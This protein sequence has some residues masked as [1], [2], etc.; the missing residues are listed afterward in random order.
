MLDLRA[1]EVLDAIARQGSFAQAAR[2][3]GRV[4]S[5]ITYV[6]QQLEHELGV[7]LFDRSGHRAVLT[8]AGEELVGEGRQLMQHAEALER[9]VQRV[10][11]GWE[12]ELRIAV[13]ALIRMPAVLALAGAFLQQQPSTRLRLS[14]EVLG[15]T[16]DALLSRRCDLALGT[17]SRP[18]AGLETAGLKSR[19]LGPYEMIFAVAPGHPLAAVKEPLS[20]AEVRQHRAIAIADTSRNLPAVTVN[21]LR[22]QDVLTVPSL[23]DKIDAQVAGLGCGYLPQGLISAHLSAGLLVQKR[24][25]DRIE[26]GTLEYSWNS[27]A[28]GHAMHWFL[29]RLEDPQVRAALLPS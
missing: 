19:Q 13:D 14:S 25:A 5:A 4:P 27:D 21:L 7:L 28:H 8:A 29:E 18:A 2:E 1:L 17:V 20:R 24:T 22:G 12:I 3:L 6:V 9:R 23:A 15:G 11:S 26:S 10:A 16:W